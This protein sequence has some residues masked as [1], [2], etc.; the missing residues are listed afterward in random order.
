MKHSYVILIVVILL[1]AFT[2]FSR[3][4]K[5]TTTTRYMPAVPPDSGYYKI[6]NYDPFYCRLPHSPNC[7]YVLTLQDGFVPLNKLNK[8]PQPHNTP[9]FVSFIGDGNLYTYTP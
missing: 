5:L 2:A 7:T 4:Q 3:F 6:V 9:G 1:A 8:N